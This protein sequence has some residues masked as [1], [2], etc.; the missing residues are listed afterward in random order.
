[1]PAIALPLTRTS[2]LKFP[3]SKCPNTCKTRGNLHLE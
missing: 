1:M 3:T 2:C